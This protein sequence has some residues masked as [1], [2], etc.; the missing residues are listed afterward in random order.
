[1]KKTTWIRTAAVATFVFGMAWQSHAEQRFV[2]VA[3]VDGRW[4]SPHID[5]QSEWESLKI[6]ETAEGSNV[7][8]GT[9]SITSGFEGQ[10]AIYFRFITKL[11]DNY[12][13]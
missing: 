1:M 3:G 9:L 8:E 4:L 2:Y 7:Y 5:N 13:Y 10:T 11:S 12:S 6:Y